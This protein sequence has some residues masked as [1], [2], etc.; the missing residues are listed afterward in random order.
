M[1]TVRVRS[2]AFPVTTRKRPGNAA[3]CWEPDWLHQRSGQVI[4]LTDDLG[5]RPACFHAP[6]RPK[7]SRLWTGKAALQ[8]P[9]VGEVDI[10]VTIEI[11]CFAIG[12][13]SARTGQAIQQDD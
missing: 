11:R 9:D 13:W 3:R 4:P 6:R 12:Q 2:P 8:H 5:R 7:S 1:L 10:F